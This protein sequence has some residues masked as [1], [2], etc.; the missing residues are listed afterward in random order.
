MGLLDFLGTAIEKVVEIDQKVT[1]EIE[2]YK[3]EYKYESDEWLIRKYSNLKGTATKTMYQRT[4][5]A[6]LLR[7]RGYDPSL[8]KPH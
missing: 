7:E 5:L 2:A 6:S 4:A 1:Q 3:R 8:F